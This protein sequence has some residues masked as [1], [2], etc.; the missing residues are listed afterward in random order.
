ME[1]A[2]PKYAF[3][4]EI[5]DGRETPCGAGHRLGDRFNYPADNGKIC[6][7][8][9]DSMAGFLRV[10][11]HGGTLSWTYRGTRYEKENDADGVTTEFVRC[12]DPTASG[13]VA[14]ITRTRVA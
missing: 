12:P 7:W 1:Q 11:E 3:T 9:M 13:V 2:R 4:I 14:K 8:L 10:L 5:F 6:P